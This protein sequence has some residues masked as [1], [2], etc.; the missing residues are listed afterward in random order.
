MIPPRFSII[1][2]TYNYARFLPRAIDSALAQQED[3]HPVEVIVIDDGSTDQTLSVLMSYQDRITSRVQENG[4]VSKARNHGIELS[5]GE[6]L[7]F[8]DAD[9]ELTPTA[10][11]DFAD[12]IDEHPSASFLLSRHESV[13]S[14]GTKASKSYPKLKSA[15]ENFKAFLN[16]EFGICQ[17]GFAV[18]RSALGEIRYPE[19]ISNGEDLVVFGLL[20]ATC[21]TLALE[22]VTAHI[23][24]HDSRARDN[25]SGLLKSGTLPVERL[26]EAEQLPTEAKGLQSL[27]LAR[28]HLSLGRALLKAKRKREAGKHYRDA[29]ALCPQL[30]FNATHFGRWV[31]CWV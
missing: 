21:E 17:G 23:H 13:N 18:R 30:M 26:F 27:F 4:G 24:E 1:I 29:F 2:P 8:L 25:L 31:R 28:R 10:V 6:W 12:A 19:G 3:D 9:D 14:S 5:Q 16:R 15:V 20:L 11:S 7:I 22:A